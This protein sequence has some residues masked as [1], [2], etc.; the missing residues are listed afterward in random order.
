M[1]SEQLPREELQ[2]DEQRN[3]EV[4]EGKNGRESTGLISL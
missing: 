1:N 2:D 4:Y 3:R